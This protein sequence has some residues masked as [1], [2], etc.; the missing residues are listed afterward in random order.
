MRQ[1]ASHY[2]SLIRT[3]Y[4]EPFLTTETMRFDDIAA[5]LKA[6]AAR[7]PQIGTHV[8]SGAFPGS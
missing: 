4:G 3:K 7:D 2:G 6:I 8:K 5:R 1:E